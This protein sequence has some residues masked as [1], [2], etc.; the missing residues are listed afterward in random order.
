MDNMYG[1]I[2]LTDIPKELITV[3][4]NGKKYLR[5]TVSAR[6][7]P[8]RFGDTHY[9]KAYCR[10]EERREG[11]NYY[12]GELRPAKAAEADG[13]AAQASAPSAAPAGGAYEDLP[14]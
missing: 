4:K 10:R 9:I 2:C 5:V 13:T 3:G 8:S 6:R 7:T 12:I 11:A 1:S 14:F